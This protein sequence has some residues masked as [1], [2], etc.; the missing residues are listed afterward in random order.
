MPTILP[1]ESDMDMSLSKLQ[2]LVMDREAW[3]AAV[4]EVTKSQTGLN[5]WTKLVSLNLTQPQFPHLQNEFEQTPGVD[6]GQGDLVCC[7]PWGFKES[8][9]TGPL[10]WTELNW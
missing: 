10:K 8:D 1:N 4:H 9:M 2:E 3:H 5:D 7:S 6:D